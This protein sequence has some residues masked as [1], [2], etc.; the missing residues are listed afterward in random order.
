MADLGVLTTA[1]GGTVEIVQAAVAGTTEGVPPSGTAGR[2]TT[3]AE[4][5][6][7]GAMAAGVLHMTTGTAMGWIGRGSRRGR[8]VH[9]LNVK[10]QEGGGPPAVSGGGR[11]GRRRRRSRRWTPRSRRG[12]WRRWRAA[13]MRRTASSRSAAA[14]ASKSWQSTRRRL[15]WWSPLPLPWQRQLRRYLRQPP[16]RWQ[17]PAR[18]LGLPAEQHPAQQLRPLSRRACRR[19]TWMR[20]ARGTHRSG[21]GPLRHG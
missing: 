14:A 6:S 3:T 21:K 17:S 16:V 8:S 5:D 9:V 12:C 15:L 2:G 1:Y 11:S 19:A 10:Q 4:G 20:P 13:P 7:T 18:A